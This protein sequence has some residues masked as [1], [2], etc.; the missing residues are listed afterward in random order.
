[1][2]VAPL[3]YTSQFGNSTYYGLRVNPSFEQAVGTVRNPY[4]IPLPDRWA[5]WWANSPY[6]SLI[7]DAEAKYQ[8][9][10]HASID[11]KTSG[12]HLPESAARVRESDAGRDPAWD[13]IHAH[14]ERMD[15]HDAYETAFQAMNA[16]HQQREAGERSQTLYHMYGANRDAPDDRGGGRRARRGRRAPQHAH[17][18]R[19]SSAARAAPGARS[20]L[21]GGRPAAGPRVPHVG[22]AQH[23]AADEAHGGP[24]L[25]LRCSDVRK[26]ARNRSS[27]EQFLKSGAMCK[28]CH[29]SRA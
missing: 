18:P 20:S 6:R 25:A 29:P 4:R 27:V 16:E 26:A 22:G 10:E 12:A 11:Y 8:D 15:A 23:A 13:E 21:H 14:N 5:K 9:Y 1:M 19:S 17:A 2:P 28:P 7:L 24:R 3:S